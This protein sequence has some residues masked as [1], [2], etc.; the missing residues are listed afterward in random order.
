[1]SSGSASALARASKARL[2]RLARGLTLALV[3]GGAGAGS[4]AAQERPSADRFALKVGIVDQQYLLRESDAAKSLQAEI[5]ARRN[6]YQ[7]QVEAFEDELIALGQEFVEQSPTLTDAEKAAREADF[8]RRNAELEALTLD[9]QRRLNAALDAGR[10]ILLDAVGDVT[11]EIAAE[12]GLSLVLQR[13]TVPFYDPEL[14][15]T[16]EAVARLNARLPRIELPEQ[17]N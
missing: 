7:E 15:L 14:D 1:M 2:R 5:E 6:R 4:V 13:Q 3:L 16:D 8:N 9:G 17:K 11:R 10:A 12:Q